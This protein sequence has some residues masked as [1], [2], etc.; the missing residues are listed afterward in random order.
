MR[1][2]SYNNIF[3]T[4]HQN[5]NFLPHT[6]W[7]KFGAGA[8]STNFWCLRW[9]EQSR[10]NKCTTFPALS[11]RTCSSMCRGF[12]MNFSMNM[13]P[14]PKAASA[15]LDASA[16]LSFTSWCTKNNAI[17]VLKAQYIIVSN[18]VSKTISNQQ[19]NE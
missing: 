1:E 19:K 2:V 12:S 18:Q 8:T 14:F 5:Q 7:S 3:Q 4:T 15:S 6:L 17:L 11:P 16:K 13:A 9:T 10:S